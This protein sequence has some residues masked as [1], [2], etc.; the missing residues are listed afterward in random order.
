M[1]EQGGV[2]VVV[3]GRQAVILLIDNYDSFT[4]NLVQ[5]LW[6]LGQDV[7]VVTNDAVSIADIEKLAPRRIVVSPG[8]CTPAEAGISVAV[9]QHFADKLPILGVCL[10]HQALSAAM[11]GQVIRAPLPMHGKVSRIQ[12]DG[13]VL[14]GGVASEF[15]ATRYHSL[16]VAELPSSLHVTASSLDDSQIMAM[17]LVDRPVFGVQFHPESI[18]TEIGP[19]LLKNF[20]SAH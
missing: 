19:T 7:K 15:S 20:L 6:A 17:Q 10:G 1:L 18:L 8:P 13:S 5:A 2:S 16:V 3:R 9:I 4:W 14:F 12:H 11:G